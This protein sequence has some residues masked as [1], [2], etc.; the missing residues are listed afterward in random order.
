MRAFFLQSYLALARYRVG[1]AAGSFLF[2]LVAVWMGSR[3]KLSDDYTDMLPMSNQTI[4][5]QVEALRYVR[6]ADRLFLDVQTLSGNPEQLNA[7]ADR[8]HLALEEI[9]RLGDI[10]YT[11]DQN[12]A[13]EVYDELVARLPELLGTADLKALEERLKP[14]AL[15]KRLAWF[16]KTLTQPQGFTLQAM[17]Q[18]D[19]VGIGDTVMSRLKLLQTG[20][21]GAGINA[22]RI[23]SADGKH[24]LLTALPDFPPSSTK[25]SVELLERIGSAIREI[26]GQFKESGM[27][28]IRIAFTG[29]HRIALD[30]AT[31][32][33]RDSTLTGL[34][35]TAAV[36]ALLLAVFRRRLLS[37]LIFVPML[38]G[39]LAAG[40]VFFLG[41]DPVSAVALGC[42][43]ILVGVTVDY[44]ILVLYSHEDFPATSRRQQGLQM[45]QM[46]PT[47]AFGAITTMAAFLVMFASPVSGHRQLGVFGAVAVGGAAVFAL[48]FLP[49]FIPLRDSQAPT[50]LPLTRGISRLFRWRS[51]HSGAVVL[52]VAL[53]SAFCLLGLLRLRFDGDLNRFNGIRG[54]TRAEELAVRETWGKALSL[55]TVIAAGSTREE[56]LA[57]NER[58]QS[59]VSDLARDGAIEAFSSIASL[60]PS[61]DTR[62][63][64]LAAWRAFWS[65]SRRVQL[66]RDL[67]AAASE[68][69]FRAAAFEGFLE[70]LDRSCSRAFAPEQET[71]SLSRILADFCS[72]K[73]GR[74][75]VSTL[76]KAP[77]LKSYHRLRD[78]LEQK[79]P[80]AMLLNKAAMGDE[81]A[82]IARKGLPV[83]AG[84]VILLNALLLYL[85]LG[86]LALVGLTLLP[87]AS[88]ILWTLG[89]LGWSGIPID[90]SN[91]IF[92]ILVLGV[93]GDYSLFL[94]M[95]GLEPLRGYD[96]RSATT[97]GAVTICALTTLFGVGVL[98]L[99]KHPALFS[100][101]ITALLGILLSLAASLLLVPLCIDRLRA[102]WER[103]AGEALSQPPVSRA[104]RRRSVHRLYS[105]QE[106]YVSQYAFW[107][108]RTDPLFMALDSVIPAQGSIL[109][110]GCGYGVVANWL[111]LSSPERRVQ[112]IDMDASKVRVALASSR[113]NPRV[114]FAERNVLT[115]AF[116]ECDCVLMCDLLHYL[117]AERKREVL[118]RAYRALRPGG[119]LVLRDAFRE[120]SGR[121][122]LT[123]FSERI[124][125][126]LGQNL[127]GFGLHFESLAQHRDLLKECG[128]VEIDLVS[129]AGMGSNQMLIA[130]KPDG[131][132]HP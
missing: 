64:N 65:D 46:A 78:H 32:I 102:T 47:V 92:V 73:D 1:V 12:E 27:P 106:P 48:L 5:R 9:P 14:E 100:I 62:K 69:G 28:Q 82:R 120:N 13:R 101:G 108:L 86:R 118:K 29:A 109:D 61:E 96:E 37:L 122:R 81:I 58:V 16:H 129:K 21:G 43:S 19:P 124:G 31:T 42:G 18:A 83:F 40:V 87:M 54:Q 4:A 20:M 105:F 132:P 44:G 88:G 36:A 53:F 45:L 89:I 112:G 10:R 15:R 23:T 33:K 97:G 50:P 49:A 115:A 2:A 25:E 11:I 3:L 75:S 99:A 67:G 26:E 98:A 90:M 76:V 34:L 114:Q 60:L 74:F 35:A 30:N 111:T 113:L 85:F 6:Q 127:A 95:A 8:L 70:L 110:L 130:Q 77:D 91:F 126:I 71:G 39:A 119:R 121:H 63:G 131:Q 55:T 72:Q 52:G 68:L 17:A 51:G 128:F 84:L 22:G 59:A 123:A 80:E 7:A 117:P 24:V 125:V 103:Q 107:K 104:E 93:G 79:V 41:G 38:F 94:V 116:P 57:A 56:A 66:R